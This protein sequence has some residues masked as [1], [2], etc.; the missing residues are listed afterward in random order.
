V[1]SFS[2][3]SECPCICAFT[4]TSDDEDSKDSDTKVEKEKPA[5]IVLSYDGKYNRF[6]MDFLQS[7]TRY[8]VP[9][10]HQIYIQRCNNSTRYYFYAILVREMVISKDSRTSNKAQV[11]NH[12]VISY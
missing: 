2:V 6:D 12:R 7:K 10:I 4:P 3:D 8:P 11:G 9:I 5:V 1:A